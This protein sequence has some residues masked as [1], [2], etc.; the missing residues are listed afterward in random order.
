MLQVKKMKLA[1]RQFFPQL[2]KKQAQFCKK[3][4]FLAMLHVLNSKRQQQS[5]CVI[6][7]EKHSYCMCKCDCQIN[8][9]ASCWLITICEDVVIVLRMIGRDWIADSLSRTDLSF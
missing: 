2:M 9:V 7:V 8:E 1:I 5:I 4:A 6:V 3:I